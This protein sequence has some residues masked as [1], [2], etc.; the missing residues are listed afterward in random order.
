[1]RMALA[2]EG[3]GRGGGGGLSYIAPL[4]ATRVLPPAPLQGPQSLH[5]GRPDAAA[6][7]YAVQPRRRQHAQRVVCDLL[8]SL[9]ARHRA[10]TEEPQLPGVACRACGGQVAASA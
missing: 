1:M 5:S 9:V 10:D 3:R 8:H 2:G 4:P 7:T 6:S